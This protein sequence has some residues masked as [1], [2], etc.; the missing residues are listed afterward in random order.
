MNLRSI[1]ASNIISILAIIISFFGG[2]PGSIQ[3]FRTKTKPTIE[4]ITMQAG[5][6]YLNDTNHIISYTLIIF[7]IGN[8]G[9]YNL[10]KMGNPKLEF[11]ILKTW[12]EFDIDWVNK[13]IYNNID[14]NLQRWISAFN[15][16][17]FYAKN[18]EIIPGTTRQFF[19]FGTNQ[20][21]N[22]NQLLLINNCRIRFKDSYG[23]DHSLVFKVIKSDI[24]E[25]DSNFIY[26]KK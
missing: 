7:S 10:S 14:P 22:I 17:D 16:L 9:K 21:I 15:V 26:E 18:P 25:K 5:M 6:A 4:Y 20:N 11:D 1:R 8:I 12:F 19:L 13:S 3:S 23:K 24:S 2:I